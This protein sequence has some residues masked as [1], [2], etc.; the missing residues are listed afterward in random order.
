MRA[1]TP[2]A[3][4]SSDEENAAYQA[5]HA[6]NLGKPDGIGEVD[7]VSLMS[8]GRNMELSAAMEQSTSLIAR[9]REQLKC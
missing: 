6:S 2:L 9:V 5:K 3:S 7:G 8:F 4:A 1:P